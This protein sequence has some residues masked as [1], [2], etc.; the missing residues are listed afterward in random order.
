MWKSK[1]NALISF[2]NK[3]LL[4]YGTLSSFYIKMSRWELSKVKVLLKFID[5]QGRKLDFSPNVKKSIFWKVLNLEL[6]LK[7]QKIQGWLSWNFVEIFFSVRQMKFYQVH[8]NCGKWI[9]IW[10]KVFFAKN[11]N[12]YPADKAETWWEC[13]GDRW[14]NMHPLLKLHGKLELKCS[15]TVNLTFGCHS[16]DM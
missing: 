12:N 9:N 5:F 10:N 1:K 8:V 11:W 15:K 2:W 16:D 6:W 7:S 4:N 14:M 3:S 13:I